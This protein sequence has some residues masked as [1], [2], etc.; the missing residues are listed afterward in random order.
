MKSSIGMLKILVSVI[1]VF[2]MGSCKKFLD[3]QANKILIL[4]RTLA[5]MQTLLDNYN[6]MNQR[7]GTLQDIIAGD[8]YQVSSDWALLGIDDRRHYIWDRNIAI[9]NSWTS[10][11]QPVFNSNVVL[12][13]L[14]KMSNVADIAQFNDIKGQALFFRSFA[15]YQLAQMYCRPYSAT[16]STDLG[17][18]VRLSSAISDPSVRGTVQQTYDQIIGDLKASVNLLP[19]NTITPVR[20]S[21]VAAY[22]MLARV[23]TSMRE[24]DKAGKYADSA[25]ALRSELLDYNTLDPSSQWPIPLMNKEV[26]FHASGL[27]GAMS[28]PAAKIDTLLYQQYHDDDLRK[29]IFFLANAD[30]SHSFKGTYGTE[31][32]FQTFY[33]IAIDELY[34]IRAEAAARAGNKDAALIDLNLLLKARWKN[35]VPYPVITA[36]S[37]PEALDKILVERRKELVCRG[38]RWTDLRRRNLEGAN[39][40]LTRV[41]NNTTY[42]LPP[43]DLR[44]VLLIPTEIINMN[45]IQQNPR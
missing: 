37:A 6:V 16:A 14:N 38:A 40:T 21:K 45:G 10:L 30:N 11:Y 44:W 8:I 1:C 15:F 35:S 33:G 24:Y 41:I 29:N 4:P 9:D 34:L 19:V 25:L 36:A 12:D 31:I 2:A 39:I 32:S 22:G 3:E 5:D 27:T 28:P 42:T 23:Y 13:E 17:I 7:N 20:P 26:I 18:C 43:N